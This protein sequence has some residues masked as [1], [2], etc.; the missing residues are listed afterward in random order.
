MNGIVLSMDE[1]VLWVIEII[2]NWFYWIVLENDGVIIVLFGVII[3]YY[4]IG[5]EGLDFCCID[6]DDNLYVVMYG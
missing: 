2:I 4:F 6:S 1:K 3:L 5:Y